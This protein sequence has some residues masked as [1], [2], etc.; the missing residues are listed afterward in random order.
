MIG[1]SGETRLW[2]QNGDRRPGDSFWKFQAPCLS[3]PRTDLMIFGIK[4]GPF[5]HENPDGWPKMWCKA[6][7]GVQTWGLAAMLERPT[8]YMVG[9]RLLMHFCRPFKYDN[10]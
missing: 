9:S 2:R 5:F 7:V 10:E 3:H 8:G 4:A 1:R 6:R